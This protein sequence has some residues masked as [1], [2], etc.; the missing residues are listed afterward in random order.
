[1]KKITALTFGSTLLTGCVALGFID[2][3]KFMT[4]L[5]NGEC[6]NAYVRV[7]RANFG[8]SAEQWTYMGQVEYFCK[9][10]REE[11]VRLLTKGASHGNN[12]AVETLAR[13]GERIPDVRSLGQGGGTPTTRIDLNVSRQ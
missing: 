8:S 6:T 10:N 5:R 2:D 7:A 9:K 4:E 13:I 11:G 3:D 1:M 12:W